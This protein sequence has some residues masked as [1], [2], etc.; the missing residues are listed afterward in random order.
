MQE[1]GTLPSRGK[2]SAWRRPNCFAE[3]KSCGCQRWSAA[4]I[5]STTMDPY[6]LLPVR[7][8]MGVTA[9]SRW[10][11][12]PKWSFPRRMRS[13]NRWWPDKSV[14]RAGNPEHFQRLSRLA[15]AQAYFGVQEARGDLAGVRDTI[16]R[17]NLMLKRIEAMA[18]DL[19]PRVEVSR[20]R[21]Q[22]AHFEQN[23]DSAREHWD[24][25]SASLV[26]ILR[27]NPASIVGNLIE[28]PRI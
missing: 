27:M 14:W 5:I 24:V 10:D 15:V 22:L 6:R 26:R 2:A 17:T 23:E 13:L 4:W 25:A 9:Q 8:P 28:P 11:S 1:P 7:L 18:P 21:A 16:Q 20:A 3:A 12:H 19:V